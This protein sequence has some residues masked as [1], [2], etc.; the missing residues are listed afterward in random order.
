MAAEASWFVEV[1]EGEGWGG[2]DG[3]FSSGECVV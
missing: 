1:E 3:L 2:R